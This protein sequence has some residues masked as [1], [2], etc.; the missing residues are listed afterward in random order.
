[1]LNAMVDTAADEGLLG[2]ALACMRL[3][4]LLVMATNVGDSELM[5]LPGLSRA[6]AAALAAAGGGG[7]GAGKGGKGG[8]GG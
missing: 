4:Q 8:K 3:A 1:M 7:G 5:Q 2:P 6:T